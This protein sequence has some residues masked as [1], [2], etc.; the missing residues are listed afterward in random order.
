MSGWWVR[1]LL[2]HPQV[3][4]AA[5]LAW[6]PLLLPAPLP[7]ACPPA[8]GCEISQWR[9]PCQL[10]SHVG[11]VSIFIAASNIFQTPQPQPE[12]SGPW[13]AAATSH[14]SEGAAALLATALIA[15]TQRASSSPGRCGVTDTGGQEPRGRVP[16]AG[17]AAWAHWHPYL[18]AAPPLPCPETPR[19]WGQGRSVGQV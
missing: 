6:C 12:R 13:G 19:C 8:S 18:K 10:V 7:A 16:G 3:P 2:L 4:C 17:L 11:D 15:A 5:L 1:A 9:S 14:A